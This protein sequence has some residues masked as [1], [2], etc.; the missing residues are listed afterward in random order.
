VSS[1][2]CFVTFIL[3]FIISHLVTKTEFGK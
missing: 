3:F 1:I 2:N